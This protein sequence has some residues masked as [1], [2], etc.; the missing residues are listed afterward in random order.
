MRR[1]I[2]IATAGYLHPFGLSPLSIAVDGYLTGRTIE[3]PDEV[4]ESKKVY[5]TSTNGVTF[6]REKKRQ[7]SVNLL[8]DDNEVLVI[9]RMFLTLDEN[10]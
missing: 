6:E 5:V 1:P 9:L 10:A 3:V 4:V 8:K 2:T 7:L